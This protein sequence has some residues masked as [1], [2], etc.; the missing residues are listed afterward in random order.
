VKTTA[1]I[2]MAFKIFPNPTSRRIK[3]VIIPREIKN[4]LLELTKI[5]ARVKNKAKKRLIKKGKY[6]P[7]IKIFFTNSGSIKK[8]IKPKV[9]QKKKIRIKVGKKFFLRRL[10]IFL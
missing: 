8:T 4:P 6:N 9:V 7:G 10:T 1:K 2:K 5:T 3:K